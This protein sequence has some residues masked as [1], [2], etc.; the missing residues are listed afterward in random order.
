[1]E[2]FSKRRKT[3][4]IS[5]MNHQIIIVTVLM[6]LFLLALALNKKIIAVFISI[7]FFLIGVFMFFSGFTT[8]RGW[9]GMGVT[10]AGI[11]YGVIGLITILIISFVAYFSSKRDSNSIDKF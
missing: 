2:L 1:M 3:V 11:I 10:I 9:E 8:V 5:L 4:L 7:S 6:I